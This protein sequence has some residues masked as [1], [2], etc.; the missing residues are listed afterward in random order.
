[1]LKK[2]RSLASLLMALVM[3]VAFS[4]PAM[5]A[6]PKTGNSELFKSEEAANTALLFNE[7]L[8]SNGSTSSTDITPQPRPANVI[9]VQ[10]W[11]KKPGVIRC[12]ILNSGIDML[13]NAT[14]YV[15]YSNPY[16]SFVTRSRSYGAVGFFAVSEDFSIGTDWTSATAHWTITDGGQTLYMSDVVGE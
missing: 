3:L 15:E 14:V 4:I 9:S 7:G 5:A 6:E 8:Q 12:T 11:E 1:M 10:A 13:D 2:R 16:G